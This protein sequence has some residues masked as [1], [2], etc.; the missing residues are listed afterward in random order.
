M[1]LRR[2]SPFEAGCSRNDT[3]FLHVYNWKKLA[4]L[5][6]DD[7]NVKIVNGHRV[8]PIDVAVKNGAIFLIPEPKSPP[9]LMLA[10]M[11]SIS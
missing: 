7:K 10:Q 8:I 2:G 1:E 4:E 5:A 11:E 6:K 3:D 9:V